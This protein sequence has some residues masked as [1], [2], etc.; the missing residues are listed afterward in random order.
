MNLEVIRSGFD[1][2][3]LSLNV[4]VPEELCEHLASAKAEAEELAKRNQKAKCGTLYNGEDL[5]VRPNGA[6]GGYAYSVETSNLEA[7]WFLRKSTSASGWGVRVAVRAMPLVLNGIAWVK[8]ELEK[9]ADAFGLSIPPNGVS[10]SRIDYAVDCLAPG[11]SFNPNQFVVH[12]ASNTTRH[13]QPEEMDVSGKCWK[14]SSMRVGGITNKQIGIYDK[15]QEVKQKRKFDMFEIWDAAR[16]AQGARPL[17]YR[18]EATDEI[19]RVELRAGKDYL[20]GRWDVTG[21]GSLFDQITDI[22]G[23]ILKTMRY[24]VPVR[25]TNRSRWDNHPLWNMVAEEVEQNALRHVPSVS[26]ERLVEVRLADKL[27]WFE[28]NMLGNAISHAALSGKHGDQVECH[29]EELAQKLKQQNRDH[30]VPADVRMEAV[31]R[32]YPGLV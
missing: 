2:L 32:R 6:A 8:D 16:H 11:F 20:K 3:E 21:W 28:T 13:M 9:T 18:G 26:R 29:L 4:V 1:K 22:L 25:D 27:Q 24:T 23:G 7:N 14:A 15:L 5:I 30:R 17:V 12:S 31:R 10:I 19:W